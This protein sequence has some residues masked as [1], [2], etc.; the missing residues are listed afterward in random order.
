[1]EHVLRTNTCINRVGEFSLL[2][3]QSG[4]SECPQIGLAITDSPYHEVMFPIIVAHAAD[5]GE[6]EAVGIT[7]VGTVN[8]AEVSM[9]GVTEVGV[10][11]IAKVSVVDI[12][13]VNVAGIRGTGTVGV[14]RTDVASVG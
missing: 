9:V 10:V 5:I 12:V 8:V 2:P 6:I 14:R 3:L 7:E 1:M 11:G 4:G 13:E